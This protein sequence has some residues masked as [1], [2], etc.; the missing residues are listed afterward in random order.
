[1]VYFKRPHQKIGDFML[2]IHS[3]TFNPEVLYVF[4]HSNIGPSS[5]K[6]HAHD[7]LELSILLTGE[8][9]YEIDDKMHHLQQETILVLNPGVEHKEYAHAG[10]ES[11]QIHIGLRHFNFSG[12]QRDFLPLET[13]IIQLGDYKEKFFDT[14]Q[15]IIAERNE[16]KPGYELILKA[17]V[18]KLIVYLF[19]DDRTSL[20]EERLLVSNQEKQEFVNEVKLYIENHYNEEL[21][22]DHIA[23]AFYTNSTTLSRSFKQFAGDTPINYLITYRLEKAKNMIQA[24][25]TLSIKDIAQS[26]G[27]SDSLYFSKLFKK[28]YGVSPSFFAE[29]DE[30]DET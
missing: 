12:Y 22:L 2:K 3:K 9:F 17:L 26:V 1:V 21:T 23:H 19:R 10:M 5:G 8:T 28:Q 13:N 4:D 30:R 15:E 20:S 24:H 7:F 6:K 27:Y 18:F 16:A 11:S 29:K 25:P 14:C